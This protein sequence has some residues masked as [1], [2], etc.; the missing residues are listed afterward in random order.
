MNAV[1]VLQYRTIPMVLPLSIFAETKREGGAFIRFRFLFVFF[2]N[3]DCLVLML[4]L[5]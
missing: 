5:I 1:V 2:Q 3:L 4:L